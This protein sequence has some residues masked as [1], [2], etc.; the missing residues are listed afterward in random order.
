MKRGTTVQ[1]GPGRTAWPIVF[2][3][4]PCVT[5]GAVLG[6]GGSEGGSPRDAG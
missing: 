1:R 2:V 5:A 3:V 4:A 6:S